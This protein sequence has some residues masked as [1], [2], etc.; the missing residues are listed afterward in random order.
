VGA[1][2][3][4]AP[5]WIAVPIDR[6]AREHDLDPALVRLYEDRYVPMVRLA[7]VLV[8]EVDVAEAIVE[9]A[10]ITVARRLPRGIDYPPA[11]LRRRVV[12]MGRRWSQRW[13]SPIQPVPP[14]AFRRQAEFDGRRWPAYCTLNP[15]CRAV[16][17]LRYAEGLADETVALLLGC[18]RR[19]VRARADAALAVLASSGSVPLTAQE[20]AQLLACGTDPVRPAGSLRRLRSGI[21][22]DRF[23][24][25]GRRRRWWQAVAAATAAT[26]TFAV[27]TMTVSPFMAAIGPTYG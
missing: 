23:L 22:L 6:R 26:A 19:T 14:A 20:V 27:C 7:Y 8:G 17:A 3:I 5:P 4:M 25:L 9:Q 16:L 12:L 13:P 24:R 2:I 11:F 10:Y 18:R 15:R 1:V 21:E